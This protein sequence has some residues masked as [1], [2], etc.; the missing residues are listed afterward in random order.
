[1]FVDEA[2]LELFAGKGGDGIVA[3]RRELKV[4]K[5]GPFGGS[6]GKG[7]DIIFKAHEG[8]ST[9]LDLKYN[10]IIKAPNGEKGKNKGMQ[11]AMAEDFYINVPIGTTIFDDDT[12]KVIGDIKS[13]D[14]KVIVCHG[15]RGGRGNIAFATNQLKCPD[16]AEKGEPG[17]HRYVRCE[18]R[19]LADCGLVGYPSVGKSTL[20]SCVSQARPKIAAYH[21]TTLVPNLGMVRLPDERSFV[22]ADLPGLIKG[23]SEGVG[24]GFDFL[25]HI[26]RCR[27]IVHIIDM[28]KTDGRDPYQDY[29]DI[30]KELESFDSTLL[31]RPMIIVANKMDM[32]GAEENL[33]E[34]KK[35]VKKDVIAIS[36][37]QKKNL[38]ELLYKIADVLETQSEIT[39]FEEDEMEEV[40]YTYQEDKNFE[41]ELDSDGV[42]NV[43]G[44]KIK[45]L[46]DM[47][48][49]D[50]ET[51]RFRFAR[52]LRSYGL[53]DALRK[54]GVKNGDTV[55]IFEYE[56]EFIE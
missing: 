1:M 4:E 50:S 11:G 15:G 18:L 35:K 56:F 27:V 51:A 25:K 42:F 12:G 41:I 5:G 19:V 31:N 26:E 40:T 45:R 30:N 10:T 6:G 38:D 53:D 29:L 8:M 14:D 13:K 52:Q 16:F 54:R 20:I 33:A 37:I 32:P 46:F 7:A 2:K 43:T 23:A 28:A 44:D 47:T 9:L 36:T 39:L 48:D 17:E 24:L 49:F 22:M 21:F 55:R 34:F 3:Y